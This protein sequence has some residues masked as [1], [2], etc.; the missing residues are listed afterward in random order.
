MTV[1]S[2]TSIGGP[3]NT[4]GSTTIFSFPFDW[5]ENS[6]IFV[7]LLN[8]ST[9][10]ITDGVLTTDFSITQGSADGG[11]GTI[12]G[13]SI[14]IAANAFS[15]LADA[16]GRIGVGY[17]ITISR[18][19]PLLQQQAYPANGAFPSAAAEQGYDRLTIADQ[20]IQLLLELCL[21]F[22]TV[23]GQSKISELPPAAQRASMLL[24]FDNLGNAIATGTTP[25]T[26]ILATSSTSLAIALGSKTFTTQAGKSFSVGQFVLATSAANSANYMLGQVTSYSGTSL[27][28][29][30]LT[31]GGSGTHADWNL[32]ISGPAGA[33]GAAGTAYAEVSI[34]GTTTAA[35]GKYYVATTALVLNIPQSTGLSTTWTTIVFA[36]GGNVTI[37]PNAADRINGGTIGA[38][39]TL[40][41]GESTI[42]T[43]D[44]AGNIYAGDV[45]LITNA[46]M[47]LMNAKTVK[48]NI[49]GSPANPSDNGVGAF[50]TAFG[51]APITP[52]G[53]LTLTSGTPVMNADAT[54]QTSIYYTPH[55]G[56]NIP[57]YDGTNFVNSAFAELTMTLN[58]SN[59][60][61]GNLYDLFVFLNS[62]AVTIA[63]GPAWS[64]GTSRG[65]G[66]GTTELQR[67]SGIMTNKN[68]ITLKNGA[69]TYSNIPANQAT[70]VG[71]VYMTAN[72][73]TGMQFKPAAASGG[74][75][76]ILGLYNAYNRTLIKSQSQD[77]TATWT[78]AGT[79][80]RAAN[81]STSNRIS[82][83]DGLQQSVVKAAY[84]VASTTGVGSGAAADYGVG[85][86]TT[87]TPSGL[88]AFNA[89]N[90]QFSG[91]AAMDSAILLGLNYVQA[92]ENT[93]TGVTA[94]FI[95]NGPQMLSVELEI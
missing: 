28:V 73:Q 90:S 87:T 57:I 65:T 84:N 81:N 70:Y 95:G 16:F 18:N 32:N 24:G 59:Q 55:V 8:V 50:N 46:M 89:S 13:G 75:A 37:T 9:G 33:A 30:V 79:S 14:T 93:S 68:I 38:S 69:T 62:G 45:A 47:A 66:A 58:T 64:S 42:I 26:A 19:I 92:L 85:F 72:G 60:T 43:T 63:A 20:Q 39:V 12:L 86:N 77:S 74:S 44:A 34:S 31:V 11:S 91:G 94:T 78:Y 10:A 29:N 61:S 88:T 56:S 40:V 67:V 17:T 4:D 25:A 76:N 53:R 83:L 23:D 15:G 52:Q 3:Y 82:W 49:T 80:Y 22:P 21:K 5:L 27:V 35:S 7:Q 51:L 2:T 36:E 6:D 54:A 41:Q 48:S 71:S 1:S